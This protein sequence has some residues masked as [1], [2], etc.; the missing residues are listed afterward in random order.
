[1]SAWQPLYDHVKAQN[2]LSGCGSI[3]AYN[4]VIDKVHF[5]TQDDIDELEEHLPS[6]PPEI[7]RNIGDFAWL[8]NHCLCEGSALEAKADQTLFVK[9]ENKYKFESRIGGQAA[10]MGSLISRFAGKG[11]IIH[12]DRID[13][14]LGRLLKDEQL[15]APVLK[16]DKLSMKRVHELSSEISGERHLIFEF[17][18]GQK[19]I[20]GSSCPRQNRLIIDPLSKILINTDFEKALPIAAKDCDVFIAAGLD[21]MGDDYSDAFTR[22]ASHAGCIKRANPEAITHLEITCMRD[23]RKVESLMNNVFPHFDSIGLNESE[24]GILHSASDG[25]DAPTEMTARNQVEAMESL[26]ELGPKRIHMHAFGYALRAGKTKS[27]LNSLRSLAF[28]AAVVCAAACKGELPLPEDL[29]RLRLS[30]SKRGIRIAQELGGVIIHSPVGSGL[31]DEE[32]D[33]VL[34]LPTPVVERPRMTVGLGDCVS[35]AS[36]GAEKMLDSF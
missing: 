11:A 13:P 7:L 29:G 6:K 26:L 31:Q 22:V 33:G 2:Y 24:L 17:A 35:S 8:L 27:V 25:G 3:I 10:I 18:E 30:P 20:S 23:D 19:C 1:M 12:P 5:V 14:E 21:H 28:G 4:E 16:N 9:L 36:V 34:C 32:A 15:L